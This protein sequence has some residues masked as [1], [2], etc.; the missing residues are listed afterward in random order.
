MF[1]KNFAVLFVVACLLVLPVFAHAST[2]DS[3]IQRI[4]AIV[5]QLKVA[6]GQGSNGT[7]IVS[8]PP[9]MPSVCY[10]NQCGSKTGA[11]KAAC[12]EAY[13]K[14]SCSLPVTIMAGDG[15][16]GVNPFTDA[17]LTQA[18]VD[19]CK[20]RAGD[21]GLTE[22]ACR[23]RALNFVTYVPG[24]TSTVGNPVLDAVANG[25]GL[26]LI[27][28]S[29]SDP[30]NITFDRST[31]ASYCSSLIGSAGL[32]LA[33]NSNWFTLCT[34]N[35]NFFFNDVTVGFKR[36]LIDKNQPNVA[37]ISIKRVYEFTPALKDMLG[38]E[39]CN[40][41][42]KSIA[43]MSGRLSLTIGAGPGSTAQEVVGSWNVPAEVNNAKNGTCGLGYWKTTNAGLIAAAAS[44]TVYKVSVTPVGFTDPN[45]GNNNFVLS[46]AGSTFIGR[47]YNQSTVSSQPSFRISVC[48][49]SPKSIN[50][51]FQLATETGL[52]RSRVGFDFLITS[53]DQYDGYHESS[54]TSNGVS[55]L[56][57]FGRM[58]N[59]GGQSVNN[60]SN[61]QCNDY[62]YTPA[63]TM[64]SNYISSKKLAVSLVPRDE[65]SEPSIFDNIYILNENVGGADV[66]I[67]TKE[68][69]NGLSSDNRNLFMNTLTKFVTINNITGATASDIGDDYLI[70]SEH[71][72]YLIKSVFGNSKGL[73]NTIGDI[74]G[75]GLK[76]FVGFY[77][78][79]QPWTASQPKVPPPSTVRV[80][81]VNV[82]GTGEGKIY[83]DSQ[84]AG[85]ACVNRVAGQQ[86]RYDIVSYDTSSV[87]PGSREPVDSS[88][89][90]AVVALGIYLNPPPTPTAVLKV[91]LRPSTASVIP[92]ANKIDNVPYVPG[93]VKVGVDAANDL[94]RR[95]LCARAI[96]PGGFEGVS[97][98]VGSGNAG[99]PEPAT[100]G[101]K[102]LTDPTFVGSP[103]SHNQGY[104]Y[105]FA[106]AGVLPET[107]S[108]P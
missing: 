28:P 83:K 76:A 44:T 15:S 5:E 92:G 10:V 77:G 105:E 49:D 19:F 26:N 106:A 29:A 54:V 69:Y 43:D 104:Y 70:V 9:S 1:K 40:A 7:A 88:P 63:S 102:E 39:V 85:V 12:S 31:S 45:I 48:N 66:S 55:S 32:G 78:V 18:C 57:G 13:F 81:Y 73:F 80:R 64:K 22:T 53:G 47:V 71:D 103:K 4:S 84:V 42:P 34:G 6:L 8:A 79:P 107:H 99:N 100:Y 68:G 95:D 46:R 23:T 41:G 35:L 24:S 96:I 74:C 25:S 94:L 17:R 72:Q 16:G 14:F 20:C 108:K 60:L 52:D 33:P 97:G 2:I 86:C 75:K 65:Y 87:P 93:T 82:V 89:L 91:T 51:L 90:Q 37:D 101:G 98:G 56:K 67:A 38:I 21:I 3:L 50:E 61:N 36:Y 30:A 58:E 11:D 59:V 27:N 62:V